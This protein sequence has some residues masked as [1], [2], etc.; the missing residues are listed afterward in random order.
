MIIVHARATIKPEKRDGFL[1]AVKEVIA[2][3]RREDGCIEYG[4]YEDSLTP[5]DFIFFERWRDQAAIDAHFTRA[6]TVAFLKLAGESVTQ[7][8]SITAYDVAASR[9]LA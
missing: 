4:A 2:A 5:N 3:T 7:A 1:L 6:H 8:P 9:K